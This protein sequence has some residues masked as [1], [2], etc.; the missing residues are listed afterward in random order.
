MNL[1]NGDRGQFLWGRDV[2]A[3][4]LIKVLL[5]LQV[6]VMCLENMHWSVISRLAFKTKM[7]SLT[8]ASGDKHHG[9]E[10]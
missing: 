5:G 4:Y 9:L 7:M 8:R 3:F 2:V 6:T 10:E 1:W